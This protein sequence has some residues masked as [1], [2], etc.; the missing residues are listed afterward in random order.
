MKAKGTQ[1]CDIIPDMLVSL[2]YFV[3]AKYELGWYHG[4]SSLQAEKICIVGTIFFTVN[5]QFNKF[6]E[7]LT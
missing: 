7:E 5:K 3:Q 2:R 6:Q 1:G 4:K